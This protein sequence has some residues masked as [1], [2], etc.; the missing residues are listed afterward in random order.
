MLRYEDVVLEEVNEVFKKSLR[1][2]SLFAEVSGNLMLKMVC[3]IKT[4]ACDVDS[5][6]A[7]FFSISWQLSWIH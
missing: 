6:G 7:F 4:D 1:P 5:V 2:S 3:S